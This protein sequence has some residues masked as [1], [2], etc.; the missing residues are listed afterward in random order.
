MGKSI[1]LDGTLSEH[2]GI[3]VKSYSLKNGKI[4]IQLEK[5]K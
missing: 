5:R 2:N 3:H 4:M 1:H